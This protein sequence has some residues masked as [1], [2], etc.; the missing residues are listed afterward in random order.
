MRFEVTNSAAVQGD[1]PFIEKLKFF[2]WWCASGDVT[3][4]KACPTDHTRYTALGM[5]ML[6]V[7]CV[8][9]VSFTVFLAQTFALPTYQAALIG[10]AWGL[11]VIFPLDRLIL[12]FHRKG[13]REFVRALPRLVLAVSLAFLIGD[14]VLTRLFQSEIAL[15][16]SQ[17][18]QTVVSNSRAKAEA[19][20]QSE[21]TDLGKANSDLQKR[22]DDLKQI[23]DGKEG[24]VIGEIEGRVG[25]G[26]KGEGPAARQKGQ[27]FSEAKAAYEQARTELLPQIAENKKRLDQIQTAVDEEVKHI[28]ESHSAANGLM[29]RHQAL[30]SIIKR[31]PSAALTYVPLFLILGLLEIG[32]L[33]N[34][35]A[36]PASAYDKELVLR[37][38]SAINQ[39][40]RAAAL[41]S[42]KQKRLA[43]VRNKLT[44]EIADAVTTSEL[45]NLIEPK[46]QVGEL[47]QAMI[48]DEQR[49]EILFQNV[50][51]NGHKRFDGVIKIEIE[52][53]PDLRVRLEL[54][55]EV[56]S[57]IT[58]AELDGDMRRIA[59]EAADGRTQ[60]FEL[61]SAASSSGREIYRDLPV[62]PQ[63]DKDQ[64]LRL[65]F[66]PHHDSADELPIA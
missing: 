49:Q 39:A 21:K 29:A 27:A 38:K 26:I 60:S 23:R 41:E 10:C 46:R 55:A 1:G 20:F 12:A 56:R 58:L 53:R 16:L 40:R 36:F 8:A 25:S 19:R 51:Q 65:K 48:L 2:L 54:P 61:A 59:D 64:A 7:P 37:E 14:P 57:T 28:G 42:E 62:L 13:H 32:P 44:K 17:N 31:E 4:L 3:T 66:A 33:V 63:L 47:L 22:L 34:K 18:G 50:Q 45:A 9:A 6:V 35:L 52:S 24:A 11:G 30:W 43:A 15:E 5:M